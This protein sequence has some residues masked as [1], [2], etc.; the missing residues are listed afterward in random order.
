MSPLHGPATDDGTRFWRIVRN[1]HHQEVFAATPPSLVAATLYFTASEAL[2]KLGYGRD[3]SDHP[4]NPLHRRPKPESMQDPF[5]G[6]VPAPVE[7]CLEDDPDFFEFLS[8]GSGSL[9]WAALGLDGTHAGSSQTEIR[10]L[11][12]D[13]ELSAWSRLV[14]RFWS[15][16][17]L[18]ALALCLVGCEDPRCD[19][20]KPHAWPK[21]S[22]ARYVAPSQATNTFLGVSVNTSRL[23]FRN[24]TK[25]NLE[26]RRLVQ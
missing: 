24:C 14:A 21:W 8:F 4:R 23:Q 10:L 13:R 9:D 3:E 25:C 26:K 5:A 16:A 19:D 15:R 18:V 6:C 17:V 2:F 22:D 20:G 12:S 11:M 7:V 1:Q